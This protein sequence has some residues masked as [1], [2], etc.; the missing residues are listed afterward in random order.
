M[1]TDLIQCQ[2]RGL[3]FGTSCKYLPYIYTSTT[4]STVRAWGIFN[5]PS[6]CRYL[7]VTPDLWTCFHP[8]II[9][10]SIIHMHSAEMSSIL[11]IVIIITSS[12]KSLPPSFLLVLLCLL[13]LLNINGFANNAWNILNSIGCPAEFRVIG[14]YDREENV[15]RNL[16]SWAAQLCVSLYRFLI[17]TVRLRL[18]SSPL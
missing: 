17:E 1:I 3:S 6:P 14:K 13:I 8:V 15:L 9:S 16:P 4:S 11:H 12:I 5:S 18:E 2:T 10:Q 7:I